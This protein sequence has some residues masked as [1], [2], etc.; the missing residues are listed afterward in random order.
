MSE[1]KSFFFIYVK[2][3]YNFGS[4]EKELYFNESIYSIWVKMIDLGLND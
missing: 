2:E 3:K 4:I 1:M